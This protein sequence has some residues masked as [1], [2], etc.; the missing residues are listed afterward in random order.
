[1][2]NRQLCHD[3][4]SKKMTRQIS[5]NVGYDRSWFGMLWKFDWNNAY[6]KQF[7]VCRDS[8]AL[9]SGN[10]LLQSN[11]ASHYTASPLQPLSSS[12][13]QSELVKLRNKIWQRS[14]FLHENI[15]RFC[16]N[17]TKETDTA[18]DVFSNMKSSHRFNKNTVWYHLQ[19][20]MGDTVLN[21]LNQLIINELITS[22]HYT[23]QWIKALGYVTYQ[24]H[25]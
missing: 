24:L 6:R 13:D 23:V 4:T 19:V 16:E 17:Y 5:D 21:F 2:Y 15:E 3:G 12:P 22:L 7:T 1:M 8:E 11:P 18:F 25:S 20:N 14:A 9:P 10:P